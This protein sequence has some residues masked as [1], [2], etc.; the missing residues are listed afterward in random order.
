MYARLLYETSDGE[1]PDATPGTGGIKVQVP[2]GLPARQ[3]VTAPVDVLKTSRA[4]VGLFAA[5][6]GTGATE[7]DP[8]VAGIAPEVALDST[9]GV[10]SA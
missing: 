7:G 6:V 8:T 4:V 3:P 9:I 2:R 10:G 1:L 5:P